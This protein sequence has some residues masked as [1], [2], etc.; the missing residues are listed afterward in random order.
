[1]SA[2]ALIVILVDPVTL[3]G[4]LWT[5]EPNTKRIGT[6]PTYKT[7]LEAGAREM[8]TIGAVA[9]QLPDHEAS[10]HCVEVVIDMVPES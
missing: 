4:N 6:W 7:C 8:V 10:M 9:D 1:M 3:D 5:P 2:W